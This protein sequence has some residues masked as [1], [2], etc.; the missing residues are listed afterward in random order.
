MSRR[1]CSVISPGAFT[2]SVAA[3]LVFILTVSHVL[4]SSATCVKCFTFAI[5]VN[6]F[7]EGKSAL[8]YERG[9]D[10]TGGSRASAPNCLTAPLLDTSAPH[11]VAGRRWAVTR[12]CCGR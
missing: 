12:V 8:A 7:T 10:K 4:S 6:Y 3:V 9:G 1:P 5:F 11:R 2:V